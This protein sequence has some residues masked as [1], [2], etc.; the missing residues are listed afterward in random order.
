MPNYENKNRKLLPSIVFQ[1][2]PKY[3]HNGL[4]TLTLISDRGLILLFES[5]S[6]MMLKTKT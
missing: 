4:I 1:M 2:L 3:D 5:H 6:L